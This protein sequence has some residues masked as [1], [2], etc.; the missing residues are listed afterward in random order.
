VYELLTKILRV[1]VAVAEISQ[2]I[3]DLG[4]KIDFKAYFDDDLRLGAT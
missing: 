4:L 3:N 1:N 2:P